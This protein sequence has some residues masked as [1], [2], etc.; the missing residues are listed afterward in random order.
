M[1]SSVMRPGVVGEFHKWDKFHPI[2]DLEVAE[3]A[4]TLFQ[5]LVY[6]FSFSVGYKWKAVDMVDLMPS[7]LQISC[8][9]FEANWGPLSEMTCSGSPMCLQMLS[10]YNCAVLSAVIVLL[11][12]VMMTALLRRSTTT[13][14]ES[15][16]LQVGRSMTKSIVINPPD[17]GGDLV[18]SQ[19][20]LC[21]GSRFCGL[22]GGTAI[23]EFLHKDG[24]SRPPEFPGD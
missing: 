10:R 5:F 18:R 6:L 23:H 4:E 11:H 19:G 22:T 2:V 3:D 13:K 17:L 24:H 20:Y 12:G 21:L 8:M 14:I 15:C 9:T 1:T 16:P 7:L